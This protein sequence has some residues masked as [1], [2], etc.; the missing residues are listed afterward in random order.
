MNIRIFGKTIHY[1]TQGAGKPLLLVHGWGGSGESLKTLADLAS[2]KYQTILLDLPG[3]GKSDPPNPE[4]GI[5]GYAKVVAEFLKKLNLTK[6]NYFG[7]SFGGTIGIYLAAKHPE[8]FDALVISAAP[9]KRN[10]KVIRSFR[11]IRAFT[12]NWMRLLF[13]RVFFPDSDLPKFPHLEKNFRR[14]VRQ[15]LR[16]SAKKISIPTLILWGEDD[17]YVPVTFATDLN[18]LI[19][20]SRLKIFP[21]VRHGLPLYHPELVYGEIEKFL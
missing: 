15:N 21:G 13:Y 6:I 12:P 14:I 5:G 16:S 7:H 3:F 2:K 9:F 20:N 11:S 18:K 4:W 1:T 19:K 8:L 17:T 10:K